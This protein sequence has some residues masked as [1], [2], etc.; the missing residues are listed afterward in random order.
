MP[1]RPHGR[2][3]DTQS[4]W[5]ICD[6]CGFLYSHKALSWLY[7]YV[8]PNLQNQ[9]FLV[10]KRC[11]DVP[12]DQLRPIL[13]PIDPPPVFNARPEEYAADNAGNVTPQQGATPPIYIPEL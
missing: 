8:G 11:L 10:C 5:A 12:S 1:Y 6:Y 9:R 3:D 4:S 7:Q 2:V 13:L